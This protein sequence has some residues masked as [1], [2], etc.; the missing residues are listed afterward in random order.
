LYFSQF[1]RYPNNPAFSRF[2]SLCGD[3]LP[4]PP[5]L[6]PPPPCS[7]SGVFGLRF[8]T[9]KVLAQGDPPVAFV[10]LFFQPGPL[11]FVNSP[12]SFLGSGGGTHVQTVLPPSAGLS[13]VDP[14]FPPFFRIPFP[15]LSNKRFPNVWKHP[16]GWTGR[17]YK[18]VSP[19][20]RVRAPH[21]L[22][23]LPS[24]WC[25]RA[26]PACL[27]LFPLVPFFFL[28]VWILSL[29]LVGHFQT[30]LAIVLFLTLGGL[31]TIVFLSS[32]LW[33]FSLFGCLI[34]DPKVFLCLV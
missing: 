34:P 27:I 18:G 1:A 20:G 2:D 15:W 31:F 29:R 22:F 33:F 25:L 24:P 11:T 4:D 14:P 8:F 3:F 5:P 21:N 19:R 32:V 26:G 7:L 17:L 28:L 12:T 6:L 10:F 23:V 16:P 30:T 13:T 9:V